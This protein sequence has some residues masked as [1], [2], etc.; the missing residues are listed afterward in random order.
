MNNIA[1]YNF[2]DHTNG[3]TFT[4]VQFEILVNAAP[5]ILTG[6]VIT[7]QMRESYGSTNCVEFSTTNAELFINDAVAGKFQFKSQIVRVVP[8]KYVYDIQIV[9]S[10]GDKFTYIKGNWIIHP[11]VTR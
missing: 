2:P 8:R 4:G 10:N 9:L 7:M 11:D 6:A 1:I 5:L 3:D